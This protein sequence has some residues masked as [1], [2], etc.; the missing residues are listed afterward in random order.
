MHTSP[1]GER[2]TVRA[3]PFLG[4]NRANA[5]KGW[6]TAQR[7]KLKNAKKGREKKGKGGKQRE[8]EKK[9][10]KIG[11]KGVFSYVPPLRQEN[12]H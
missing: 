10:R 11:R 7:K 8:N 3:H 5:A 2:Y 6:A 4:G 1:T 12:S 9:E